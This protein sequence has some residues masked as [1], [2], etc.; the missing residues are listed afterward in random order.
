MGGNL[1]LTKKENLRETIRGGH[2]DRFV[3]QYSFMEFMADPIRE[4]AG[5][6]LKPGEEGYNGLVLQ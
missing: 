2:P 1:M 5:V 6:D 4:E 3:D